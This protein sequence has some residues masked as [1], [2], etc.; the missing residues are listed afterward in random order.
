MMWVSTAWWCGRVVER[1]VCEARMTNRTADL[2][3]RWT[4]LQNRIRVVV[5]VNLECCGIS[6]RRAK[7]FDNI[8][9]L[10]CEQPVKPNALEVG[11]VRWWNA[12]QVSERVIRREPVGDMQTQLVESWGKMKELQ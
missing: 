11:Q 1:H 6:E 8:S 3:Q 7:P 12:L 2:L 4:V 5:E 9:E 10:R